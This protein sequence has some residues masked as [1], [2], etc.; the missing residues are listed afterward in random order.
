MLT[1]SATDK[2]TLTALSKGE[3]EYS[4]SPLR[5]EKRAPIL[6]GQELYYL[7]YASDWQEI[8]KAYR[9][10]FDGKAM[11]CTCKVAVK[12]TPCYHGGMVVWHIANGDCGC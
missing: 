8:G 6:E 10:T 11:H 2:R 4:K 12:G 5:V 7:V 1:L 3:A 9:V